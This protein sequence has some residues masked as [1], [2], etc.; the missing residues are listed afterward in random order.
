MDVAYAYGIQE[1]VL[2]AQ[3][4]SGSNTYIGALLP[5][6]CRHPS[7]PTNQV[8]PPCTFVECIACHFALASS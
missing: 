1:L 7:W 3:Q 2:L 6:Y 4:L 8:K 5:L